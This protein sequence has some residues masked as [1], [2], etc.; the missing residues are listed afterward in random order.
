M[1]IQI[2]LSTGNSHYPYV[3]QEDLDRNIEALDRA[4]EGKSLAL[5]FVL[6]T[7]TKSIL[8]AIRKELPCTRRQR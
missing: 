4:I 7:D 8:E 1:K 6:L 3:T 5:D 2:E